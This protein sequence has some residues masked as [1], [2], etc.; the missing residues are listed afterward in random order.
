MYIANAVHSSVAF[1]HLQPFTRPV[2]STQQVV[3]SKVGVACLWVCEIGVSIL[4]LL[5]FPSFSLYFRTTN[6]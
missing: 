3:R 4:N 1:L 6:I 2:G 5:Q